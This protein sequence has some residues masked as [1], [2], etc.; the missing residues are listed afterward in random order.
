MS[1]SIY[2]NI[3][4]RIFIFQEILEGY[5]CGLKD[6]PDDFYKKYGNYVHAPFEYIT[7]FDQFKKE[8]PERSIQYLNHFLEQYIDLSEYLSQYYSYFDNGDRQLIIGKLS[9]CVKQI[10]EHLKGLLNDEN[11]IQVT[12]PQPIAPPKGQTVLSQKQSV[13]FYWYLRENKIISKSVKNKHLAIAIDM[14]TGHGAGQNE[15]I[16]KSKE[17]DV[18]QLGKGPDKVVKNDFVVVVEKLENLIIM[19]R[20]VS[21]KKT[22]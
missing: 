2:R 21:T 3:Q 10:I 17:T 8:F 16:I 19:I 5:V 20:N 6:R 1:E 14:M 4:D 7:E 13:L 18:W 12:P 9:S 15:E 22:K 11:E